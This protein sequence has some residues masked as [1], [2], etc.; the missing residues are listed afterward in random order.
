MDAVPL[1]IPEDVRDLLAD[2]TNKIVIVDS[3]RTMDPTELDLVA[4]YVSDTGEL[5]ALSCWNLA[6]AGSTGGAFA[7][8]PR[9]TVDDVV[10]SG[11]LDELLNDCFYEVANIASRWLHRATTPHLRLTEV[12]T[13]WYDD[14][15]ELL[16]NGRSRGFVISVEGYADGK[17]ACVALGAHS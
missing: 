4:R 3:D 13:G 14:E 16:A 6:A 8:V 1:P 5:I 10:A 9:H 15:R 2:L 12:H 7:M 17:A 11:V